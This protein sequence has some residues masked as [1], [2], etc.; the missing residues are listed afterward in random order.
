MIKQQ[1]ESFDDTR[2]LYVKQKYYKQQASVI[3][4]DWKKGL[5]KKRP[6]RNEV[7]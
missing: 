2:F 7:V 1:A 6:E 5:F 4:I 3:F